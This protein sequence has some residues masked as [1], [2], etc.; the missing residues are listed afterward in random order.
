MVLLDV[1]GNV[2]RNLRPKASS[3]FKDIA[4]SV[5]ILFACLSFYMSLIGGHPVGRI[6][7]AVLA[8]SASVLGLARSMTSNV[9]EEL[10]GFAGFLLA[11]AAMFLAIVT[12]IV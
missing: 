1:H 10:F 8:V 2:D 9:K 3:P 11:V 7:L 5:A 12:T 6:V 4:V